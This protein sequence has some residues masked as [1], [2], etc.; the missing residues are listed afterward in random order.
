MSTFA[1]FC[2]ECLYIY[3]TFIFL[4]SFSNIALVVILLR[5]GLG[6]DPA[7]LKELSFMVLRLAFTPC[8]VETVTV[9]TVTHLLLGFPWLWGLMLG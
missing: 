7:A 4:S 6:L 1:S 5:A 8:I 9:A 2:L 3:L